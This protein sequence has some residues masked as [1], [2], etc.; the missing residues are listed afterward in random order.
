MLKKLNEIDKMKFLLFDKDQLTIFHSIANPNFNEIFCE[1]ALKQQLTE[2]DKLWR[3]YEFYQP[4]P[5]EEAQC[6]RHLRN[7]EEMNMISKQLLKLVN[8]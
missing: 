6:Y 1:K 8:K 5:F 3:K 2:I 7:S 4:N